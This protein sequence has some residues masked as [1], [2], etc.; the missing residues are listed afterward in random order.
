M[1]SFLSL[2]VQNF[3]RATSSAILR[4]TRQSS[5]PYCFSSSWMRSTTPDPTICGAMTEMSPTTR[6]AMFS[7]RET[8]HFVSGSNP[9][10]RAWFARACRAV[11]SFLSDSKYFCIAGLQGGKAISARTSAW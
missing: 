1:A 7:A 6:S 10:A 2:N 8:S 4:A 5:E 11:T 9:C 3:S